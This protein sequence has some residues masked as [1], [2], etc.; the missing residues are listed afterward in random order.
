VYPGLDPRAKSRNSAW[1]LVAVTSAADRGTVTRHNA[2]DGT[3]GQRVPAEALERRIATLEPESPFEQLCAALA[4]S[5]P[6]SDELLAQLE[7]STPDLDE[8]L[9]Q[10]EASAPDLDQLIKAPARWQ[11]PSA[12]QRCAC[13]RSRAGRRRGA[14]HC[15]NACK[16]RA[17]RCRVRAVKAAGG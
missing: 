1:F 13:G 11:L 12:A 4:A 6:I 15:G 10:L 16:Q 8:L 2:S 17:Y 3:T 5:A 14:L 7:A 9:A